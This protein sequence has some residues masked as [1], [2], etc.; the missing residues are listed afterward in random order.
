MSYPQGMVPDWKNGSLAEGLA[1][2]RKGEFFEAHEA[3]E[4][5]WLAL[6]QP[7]K[8]FLQALIKCAA[9]MHHMRRGNLVGALSH[10]RKVQRKLEE[11][12][13]EFFGVNVDALRIDVANCIEDIEHGVRDGAVH[14]PKIYVVDESEQAENHR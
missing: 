5:V 3:W 9:A 4:E 8:G 7:E 10:L 12:P 14:V 13:L 1:C 11:Y 2:Y 6:H